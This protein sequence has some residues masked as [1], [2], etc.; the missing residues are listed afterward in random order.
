MSN[1]SLCSLWQGRHNSRRHRYGGQR[2]S[3]SC[4][5]ATVK[6]SVF[7]SAVDIKSCRAHGSQCGF[8]TPGFVM[9]MYTLL[10]NKPQPT[11]ADIDD[12]MQGNLCRCTGYRP[13]LEAYY[14][15]AVDQKSGV[16]KAPASS[17]DQQSNAINGCSMGAAC[18]KNKIAD[19]ERPLLK[20]MVVCC[21]HS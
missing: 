13:I 16:L 14:S 1:T 4:S 6:V 17:A 5:R 12:A 15:F 21:E 9:A 2:S 19:E 8:C 18:C 7:R 10:R 11:H 3:A 20:V